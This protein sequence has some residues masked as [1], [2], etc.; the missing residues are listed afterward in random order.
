PGVLGA[1]VLVPANDL[2]R[3]ERTLSQDPDIAGIILEPSGASW[4]TIPL[5]PGFLQ[6]L[7]DLT[8]KYRTL[9]IFDEVITGFRWAPGGAQERYGVTPDVSS[10]AKVISGGM[11]GAAV[12]GR[13]EVMDVVQI[14][15]D[16]QH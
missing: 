14:T 7:R 10:H 3:V 1:T 9:L 5:A 12:V 11:P 15:G 8:R 6:G 4:S 16:A 2:E 13:A